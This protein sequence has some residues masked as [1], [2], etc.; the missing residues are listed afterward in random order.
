[1]PGDSKGVAGKSGQAESAW[2]LLCIYTSDARFRLALL[3]LLQASTTI[4]H[5][6]VMARRIS[7]KN[8]RKK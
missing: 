8:W 1:E 3:W 6:V 4:G 5:E 2:S 7:W